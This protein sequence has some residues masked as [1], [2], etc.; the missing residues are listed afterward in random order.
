M[1]FSTKIDLKKIKIKGPINPR[2][3]KKGVK[4]NF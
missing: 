2:A 3:K 1:D 4:M